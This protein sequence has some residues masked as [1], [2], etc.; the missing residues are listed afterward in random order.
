MPADELY[1]DETREGLRIHVLS[2]ARNDPAVSIIIIASLRY[3][4][5][6]EVGSELVVLLC[7]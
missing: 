3:W 4:G 7:C 6:V 2:D 5:L 1:Y